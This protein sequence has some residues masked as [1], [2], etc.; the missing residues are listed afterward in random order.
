MVL[1]VPAC[2]RV[3]VLCVHAYTQRMFSLQLPCELQGQ[4][5]VSCFSLSPCHMAGA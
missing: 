5:S 1:K 3:S 4:P 2:V